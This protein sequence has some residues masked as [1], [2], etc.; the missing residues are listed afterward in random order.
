MEALY[1]AGR[2]RAGAAF[3]MGGHEDGVVAFAAAA[4]EAGVALV[5][6]LA[7]ARAHPFP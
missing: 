2:L 4:E 6:A 1:R 3:V 5:R 7:Q